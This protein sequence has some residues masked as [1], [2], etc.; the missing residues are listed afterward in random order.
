MLIYNMALV[1]RCSTWGLR[2]WGR[3]LQVRGLGPVLPLPSQEEG[4]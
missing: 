2:T 3:L 4:A 1:S